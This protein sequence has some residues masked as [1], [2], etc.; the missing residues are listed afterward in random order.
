MKYEVKF[1]QESRMTRGMHIATLI[2]DVGKIYD[3]WETSGS[4]PR[5]FLVG[6]EG[7]GLAS[8]ESYGS[9]Y[10]YEH[11][12]STDPLLF[13][14]WAEPT[15]KLHVGLTG[16]GTVFRTMPSTWNKTSFFCEVTKKL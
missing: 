1:W 6:V 14:N 9:M 10:L 13:C 12:I 5:I 7:K 4:D 2:I 3:D 16:H 15:G 11:L 8:L